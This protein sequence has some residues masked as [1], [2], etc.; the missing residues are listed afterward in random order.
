LALLRQEKGS[1]PVAKQITEAVICSVNY[2]EVVSKLS[3]GG[4]PFS[5]IRQLAT[6]LPFK[7]IDF[8]EKMAFLAG[9][10]RTQTRSL[11]LSLGDRACLATGKILGLPIMTAD[12]A[13]L[14]VEIEVEIRCIR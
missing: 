9:E 1:E 3:E 2:A 6:M 7:I 13:W 4:M 8:N 10:L 12:R 5:A 14:K 11:G